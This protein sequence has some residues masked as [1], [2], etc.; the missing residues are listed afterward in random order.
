VEQREVG[1][2]A[3]A[4]GYYGEEEEGWGLISAFLLFFDYY[5]FYWSLEGGSRYPVLEERVV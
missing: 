5:C 3:K 4:Q 1:L 2:T